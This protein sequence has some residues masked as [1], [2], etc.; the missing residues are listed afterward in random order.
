MK[1]A[2][3]DRA[4]IALSGQIP[5]AIVEKSTDDFIT[6][7]PNV[8]WW[9]VIREAFAG[10]WQRNILMPVEDCAAHPTFWACVTQIA[11]DVAKCRPMLVQE[12][13]DGIETEVEV[14]VYSSVL[15]RPNHYQN[16]I[17]FVMFWI[18]C[19]LL[20]GNAYALK[21]RDAR[22]AVSD[23]YLLD[24]M[25]VKPLV[26]PNGYVFY[27][28]QQDVLAD[29]METSVVVPASEIIHDPMY[30]LYHPLCGLS[31]IYACGAVTSQ[32]MTIINN[33][34]RFFRRGSQVGGLLVAPGQISEGTAKRLEKHWQEN[35]AGEENIG[36]IAVLGDGLKFEKPPT[37]S[38]VDAQLIEQLKWDDEKICG[39]F[40]MPPFKVGVGP[41]PSYNNVEALDQ[42][43]YGGCLQLLFEQ[44]EL[45]WTEGLELKTGYEVE[46]D[47]SALD[48]MD[49][50]QRM[51]VATK[52]VAGGI[53][54][55]NEARRRFNL[56]KVPGGDQVYLQKQNWPL[57]FLGKDA[58]QPPKPEP[59]EPN[60]PNDPQ[61][62]DPQKPAPPPP[63]K[64]SLAD[65][66]G[67][68][69]GLWLHKK[70]A[71]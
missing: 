61:N 30:P 9:P 2:L 20:R 36:K 66:D 60:D 45:C 65:L 23:V 67:D 22:N 54:K 19:K 16:R 49:S 41:L 15:R 63:P 25:R 4:R 37:M 47:I 34:T 46:F 21:R 1:L 7:L 71:A 35:Y 44:L 27:A 52:G 59:S 31:P 42:I 64:K 24:P 14:P 62:N 28:L 3:R 8:G 69:V 39:A 10:A 5:R 18:L 53:F 38:N 43:Y 32:G 57:Q 13:A 17:Q 55:P 26:S 33:A 51:E 12:D 11:G 29:V 48:R 68:V 70:L 6:H 56:A 58:T 50:V 40:H